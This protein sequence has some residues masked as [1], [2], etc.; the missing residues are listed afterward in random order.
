MNQSY[1]QHHRFSLLPDDL[2]SRGNL[3]SH[4]RRHR[5]VPENFQT[6][7]DCEAFVFGKIGMA[8]GD[9]EHPTTPDGTGDGN[10]TGYW[11]L[12]SRMHVSVEVINQRLSVV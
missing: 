1:K 9:A 3:P 8:N 4:N 10:V 7:N 5:Y 2:V 6:L 12:G 11:P